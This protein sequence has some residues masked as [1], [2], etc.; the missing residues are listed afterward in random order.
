[1]TDLDTQSDNPK[2]PENNMNRYVA[3]LRG[4]N[5]SGQKIIKMEYLKEVFL[6]GGF[7]NV[8]TFIQSGNVVFEAS[9]SNPDKL[10]ELIEDHLLK[11][12][13]YKIQVILRTFQELTKM[14]KSDPF[15]PF[16]AVENIK[17]YVTFLSAK[18]D[19][20][21]VLPM[22]SPKNDV[23]IFA[24]NNL[25]FFCISRQQKGGFGFPNI[26]IEKEFRIPATTRNWNTICK[27]SN[28]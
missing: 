26:F 7:V 15:K 25:D 22:V 18:P 2:Y 10:T 5:V 20:K 27:I 14:V 16:E 23:E 9:E 11:T 19:K 24:A 12:F 8:S 21:F 17:L 4:I 13:G 3:F 28:L 1:L 6:S